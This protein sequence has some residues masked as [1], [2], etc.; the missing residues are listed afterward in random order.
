MRGMPNVVWLNGELVPAE[1][2][3]ISV[4]DQG[5]LYGHGLFETM[6]AYGGSVFRLER[7]LERLARGAELLAI[8]LPKL[9]A[10]AIAVAAT[11]ERNKLR[12]AR[13]RL[14][15]TAGEGTGRPALKA[16]G[17]PTVLVTVNELATPP[18]SYRAIYAS[19][20]RSSRNPLAD[21]KSMSYLS[22]L[23]AQQEAREQ[24]ADEA[25]L[26]NE[27]GL[28]AEGA[29]SNLFAVRDGEVATPPRS[30][31]LLPGVTRRVVIDLA[32]AAGLRCQEGDLSPEELHEAEEAFLTNSIV[33]IVPLVDVAGRRIGKGR[34]G[35]ITKRLQQAYRELANRPSAVRADGS[36]PG[37]GPR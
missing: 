16:A 20:R 13:V 26:L 11:L 19:G 30:T 10:L 22:N 18:N 6:R 21:V 34:M 23:L 17:P 31:G 8:E 7:H 14:T 35:P 5:V 28:I 15:V 36:A 9:E 4:F 32:R 27:Y 24:G 25:L 1:S 2:A 29:T 33:E 37:P 3:R 12:E